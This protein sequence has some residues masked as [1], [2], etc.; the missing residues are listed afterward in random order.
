MNYEL[1]RTFA[2]KLQMTMDK[3]KDTTLLKA[4]S[5]RS[6]LTVGFQLYTGNFRRFFKASWQMALLYAIACGC[7]GTMAA[8]KIPELT[9]VLMQQL[10]TYQGIFIEPLLQYGLS[11]L[12]LI[13]LALVA[14][15]TLAL[16]SATILAKLK[17]H[18]DTGTIT[19]P[20]HWL[21]ASPRMMGRT[22]KGVF[23]TTLIAALPYLLTIGLLAVV[24]KSQPQLLYGRLVTITVTTVIASA[25][26]AALMLPLMHVLM[27][28][29]MEAPCGYWRTLRQNYGCGMRHWGAMF[30]VFF[31]SIL[32]IE[33]VSLIVMT[34]AHILNL[35]NQTAH[36][37][38]LL[39]D[40]LGMP[41]YMTTLTFVTFMLCCFIEFY[42]SQVTMVHNY[43][44]YGTIEAKEQEKNKRGATL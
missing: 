8:I 31:V 22:V 25:I 13:G 23:L 2:R 21:T 18:K 17:E 34:P 26:I 1:F 20:P 10:A 7:L 14:L 12:A 28:Y 43:Y 19:I 44:L 5:Y 4:R 36:T 30:L 6:V 32:L 37:G 38:L 15:A 42:V 3:Q 40:P 24:A 16:A 29:L 41:S 39:G 35:A 27:K 33:L 9:M 11:L